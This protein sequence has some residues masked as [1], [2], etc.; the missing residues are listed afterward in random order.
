MFP[1]D[2]PCRALL[3]LPLRHQPRALPLGETPGQHPGWGGVSGAGR[4]TPPWPWVRPARGTR[5][6]LVCL[7]P[8]VAVTKDRRLG[9]GWGVTAPQSWITKLAGPQGLPASLT[10]GG[11][12][13]APP[14]ARLQEDPDLCVCAQSSP[15]GDQACW[16]RPTLMTSSELPHT[17]KEPISN[18]A[19]HRGLTG[20]QSSWGHNSTH[21]SW[22]TGHRCGSQ[23]PYV[24]VALAPRRACPQLEDPG[25]LWGCFGPASTLPPTTSSFCL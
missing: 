5:P 3:A 15:R 8:G 21:D 11:R 1:A 4:S 14:S 17:C 13:V 6:R 18:R 19:V 24:H 22:L 9:A 20:T 25:P 12:E 16:F 7:L 2:P 10:S 23:N